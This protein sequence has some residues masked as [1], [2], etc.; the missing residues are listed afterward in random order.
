MVEKQDTL[1]SISKKYNTTIDQL[2][3]L[4]KLSK[5]ATIYPGDKLLVR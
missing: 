2:R 3:K 4:N 1:Y 5:G